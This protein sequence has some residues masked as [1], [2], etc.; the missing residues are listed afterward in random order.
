MQY[1]MF[2]YFQ[3]YIC[4]AKTMKKKIKNLTCRILVESV[5][6][7]QRKY[8]NNKLHYFILSIKH[9]IRK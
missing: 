5:E 7:R 8:E 1:C 9:K 6:V 2:I 3:S 4:N